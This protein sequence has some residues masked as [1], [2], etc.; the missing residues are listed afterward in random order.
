[1]AYA[2]NTTVPIDRSK[3]EIERVLTKYGATSF[4][5]MTQGTRAI[6]M[7]EAHHRQIRFTLP[8]PDPKDD[9]YRRTPSGRMRQGESA[10]SAYEQE[11]RRRWRAL[12]LAIKAKLEAVDTGITEFE[13][14]FLAH[15]VLP[16]NKTVGEMIM[17]SIEE[18]YHSG[19]IVALL[20]GW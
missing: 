3:A 10:S 7:F 6:V 20:P 1:M 15:I 11:M 16:G 5:Y 17:P 14:E 2:A 4:G 9:S 8:M 19:K 18:A 12:T 13:Q